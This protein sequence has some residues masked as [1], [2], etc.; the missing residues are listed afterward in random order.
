MLSLT[1]PMNIMQD[2]RLLD[3]CLLGMALG[4]F[5]SL[6]AASVSV[7]DDQFVVQWRKVSNT[8]R[9]QVAM[10]P[11][12]NQH[13]AT[14][15]EDMAGELLGKSVRIYVQQQQ[16]L[17]PSP[18][19]SRI[20]I[21]DGTWLVEPRFRLRPDLR[22]VVILDPEVLGLELDDADCRAELLPR[23]REKHADATIRQFFPSSGSVPENLLRCYVVFDQPM[24]RGAVAEHISLLDSDGEAVELPFLLLDEELW[25][26][27]MTRLTLLLDPGR[28]KRGLVPN[29][30]E[31]R[32]MLAG[33]EY[34]LQVKAGWPTAAGGRLAKDFSRQWRVT[35]ADYEQPQP[36]TWK[37][38][39]PSVGSR[40]PLVIHFDAAIDQGLARRMISIHN[41]P[42]EASAQSRVMG[43]ALLLE[44]ENGWKFVPDQ[45]WRT[46]EVIV[47][48]DVRLEDPCGNSIRKPFE[49]TE[50]RPAVKGLGDYVEKQLS[51]R[52]P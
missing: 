19:L 33:K 50:E 36:N 25:N 42:P 45:P 11:V 4:V 2:F 32:A 6:S 23:P 27:S 26:S 14:L 1:S 52:S 10:G 15:G 51:L 31:G 24:T 49:V 47:R 46:G 9:W 18:L 40:E 41:A 5:V 38:E 34:T 28:V 39:I 30:Q 21:A 37:Y 16:E 12:V 44:D 22:Y 43:E 48:V 17:S 3:L 35:Q 8:G 7:D 20:K 29:E 13:L